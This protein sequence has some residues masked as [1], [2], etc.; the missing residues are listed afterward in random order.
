M[1]VEFFPPALGVSVVPI[2]ITG[3]GT[4]QLEEDGL[5]VVGAKVANR[6]RGALVMLAIFATV[7][8][9]IVLRYF[10]GITSSWSYGGAAASGGA[11]LM[12]MLKKPAKI[13]EEVRCT[14]P[15]SKIKKVS[16]DQLSE[17][18]VVVVKGMKPKGGLYIRQPKNSELEA[19]IRA[20]SN[21]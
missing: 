12:M 19:A 21:L 7:T 4:L 14:F 16:W 8:F 9:L 11:L 2:P 13:G 20:R 10:L 17:C 6:G 15:W 3:P 5:R 18:L 1:E